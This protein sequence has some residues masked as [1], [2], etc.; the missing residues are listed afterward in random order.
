MVSFDDSFDQNK[1]VELSDIENFDYYHFMKIVTQKT[2]SLSTF[3]TL[4]DLVLMHIRYLA[5]KKFGK[6]KNCTN[7]WHL[8]FGTLK[9]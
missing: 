6:D 2:Q 3:G 4:K 9:N 1:S 5:K 7:L 8:I